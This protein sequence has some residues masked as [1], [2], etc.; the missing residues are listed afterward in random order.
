MTKDVS[1]DIN[2]EVNGSLLIG[3][4]LIVLGIVAIAQPAVSTLFAETWF[5]SIL[6]SA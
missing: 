6:V 4:V 3:G 5:A 1:T 2:K